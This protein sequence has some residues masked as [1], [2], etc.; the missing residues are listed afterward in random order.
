MVFRCLFARYLYYDIVHSV[1]FEKGDVMSR[2]VLSAEMVFFSTLPEGEIFLTITIGEERNLY[3][4]NTV[5]RKH[6][7]GSFNAVQENYQGGA[8]DAGWVTIE[9]G[10]FIFPLV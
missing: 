9:D 10:T 7:R 3:L 6:K 1:Y 8:C 2:I 5:Y 4:G